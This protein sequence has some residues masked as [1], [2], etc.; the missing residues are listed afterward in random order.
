VLIIKLEFPEYVVYH[1]SRVKPQLLPITVTQL[2]NNV[3][4]VLDIN[5]LIKLC[6]LFFG[7]IYGLAEKGK[8]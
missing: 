2:C 6:F 1:L 7:T 4:V 3:F 8:N 5:H